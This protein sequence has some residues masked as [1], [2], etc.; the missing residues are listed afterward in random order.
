[1]LEAFVEL[2]RGF[3]A[4]LFAVAAGGK[5]RA[6][7]FADLSA[8]FAA[9]GLPGAR[10]RRFSARIL[11]AAEA[12]VPAVLLFGPVS[13]GLSLAAL[14]LTVLAGGVLVS[15][16]RGRDVRCACFGTARETLS[17]RHLWRNAS[18][19]S[20]ALVLALTPAGPT[21]L[22]LAGH[23]LLTAIGV[24]LG[25]AVVLHEA[26]SAALIPRKR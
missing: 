10:L 1:M 9:F 5:L 2:G 25:V 6:R 18:L 19:A 13:I 21:P 14:L 17:E 16:R 15:T 20:I 4:A 23:V 12:T 22:D 26:V 24:G 7:G 8:A 3:F 11:I